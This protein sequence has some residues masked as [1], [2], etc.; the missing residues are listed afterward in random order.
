MH[1]QRNTHAQVWIQLLE[2][3]HEYWMDRTIQE[4]ASVVGTPL[5][6]DNANS[7]RIYGHYARILVDID[8]SRKLYH[9]ITVEREGYAFNVEVAYGWLPEFC[10][11]CQTIGHDFSSCR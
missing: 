3:P 10:T 2:L 11:H 7:K 6:I 9:E 8:F 4:I 1:K 5:L